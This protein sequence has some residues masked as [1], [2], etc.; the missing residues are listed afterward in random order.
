MSPDISVKK[1]KRWHWLFSLISRFYFTWRHFVRF[2][3]KQSV[4][5]TTEE[6]KTNISAEIISIQPE[7]LGKV[8]ENAPKKK[9]RHLINVLFE[10]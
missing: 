4:G 10:K 9:L 6:L 1:K 3:E 8:M 2:F 7:L 5:Q